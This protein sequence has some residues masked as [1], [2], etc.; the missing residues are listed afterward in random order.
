[1]WFWHRCDG[2]EAITTLYLAPFDASCDTRRELRCFVHA[3]MLTAISQYD[4]FRP[5]A[6]FTTMDDAQLGHVARAVDAFL[7]HKVRD[8]IVRTCD[9]ISEQM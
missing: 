6:I 3:G 4:W 5:D 7:R 1:M 2:E 8:R 9:H